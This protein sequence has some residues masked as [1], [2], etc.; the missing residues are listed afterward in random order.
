MSVANRYYRGFVECIAHPTTESRIHERACADRTDHHRRI[1][2]VRKQDL[3]QVHIGV[4]VVENAPA[5]QY[6]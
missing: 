4:R 2:F 1:R 3:T 5:S 6:E